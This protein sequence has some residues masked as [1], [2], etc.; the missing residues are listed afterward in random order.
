MIRGILGIDFG[1][2]NSLCAWIE[3][4]RPQI[5]PNDRGSRT[6][7][8][9]VALSH[10]GEI[11]VGES[12]KNQAVASP[13][14]TLTGVKRRLG[15][16]DPVR[17]GDRSF[18]PE[19]AA[20]W[21]FAK[22]KRDSEAFLGFPVEQAVVSVPA[23]FGEA[24]RRAVKEAARRAGLEVPRLVNE[25]T[26]AAVARAFLDPEEADTERVVLVYDFGGGTF[27][28]TVLAA[29]GRVCE[30]LSSAGDD[31]LGGMDIDA[32]LYREAA[33]AFRRDWGVDP[34][35]DPFLAQQLMD[36][37]ER[38]KI[39]LSSRSEVTFTIPFLN[40]GRGLSHPSFGLSRARLEDL[41]RPLAERTLSLV[42][43]ALDEAGKRPM[44]VGALVLSGGSSR[45]PLVRRM[46]SELLPL[47]PEGRVNPEE[48]VAVG[49]AVEA[50]I[51]S[52]RAGGFVVRDVNS[53]TYGVEIEG[54]RF[55]ELLPRNEPL[56]SRRRRVFTTVVD[57]QES[58]EIHILQG[59]SGSA[60]ENLSLGRFLLPGIR[61]A[62]KGEPKIQ[63]EF[64]IDESDLLRVRAMDL[65]TR[66]EQAVVV[67]GSG[68]DGGDAEKLARLAARVR[69]LAGAEDI[70]NGFR[71]EIEE[72]LARAAWAVE[73]GSEEDR[74]LA[75]GSL[76]AVAGELL[77]RKK[78]ASP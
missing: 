52:G 76:E 53:R 2:T 56:P 17:L 57:G 12:A 13:Q 6:T 11:L 60:A 7:P 58:V 10:S 31:R 55:V 38:A 45:I 44:D 14:T 68:A 43:K 34:D 35:S 41:T 63:V 29:R 48:I 22:L 70:D 32:L 50:A 54:G 66:T 71:S 36:L 30:V 61:K 33:E 5:V 3:D 27:D 21:I 37:S 49:A 73:S 77:A 69:S 78:V 23:R 24:Q 16:R 62:G 47:E 39:E 4:G 40:A 72:L 64:A 51:L 1:T 28:V 59:E 26:A 67:T 65:D 42:R 18:P 46:I 25:P 75:R 20:S 74:R 15:S 8:S 9:V 19:E